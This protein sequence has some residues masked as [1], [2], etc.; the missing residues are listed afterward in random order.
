MLNRDSL[1]I[2][3]IGVL[4]FT[5]GLRPE[6]I[7][8]DCRFAMFAQEMMRNGP[9]F[10][11]TT[12]GQPYPDYPATSTFLIYLVSQLFGKVTPFTAILPTAIISALSLVVIYRIGAMHSRQWA[13]F[14]VLINLF[15]KDF[16][17]LSRSVSQDHYTSLVTVL[18]FYLAY[19][20]TVYGRKKRLCFIP[21]LLI[22][23]FATRGPIGLVIPAAVLCA[24]YFFNMDFKLFALMAFSATILFI[25]CFKGLLVAA[26]YQAGA[27]FA[28]SVWEAQMAGRLGDAK[29]WIGYYWTDSLARYAMAYPF[30]I[31]VVISFFKKIYRREN[32]DYKLLASL[33]VWI[34]VVLIGMS[35]PGTRKI[36]YVL[37]MIPAAALI[38]SYMF[39]E[40]M[41]KGILF[42]IK[43][44]FLQICFGLPFGTL[45][46]ILA[47]WALSGRFEFLSGVN[48]LTLIILLTVLAAAAWRLNNRL[49]ESV[50]RDFVFM[51]IGTL[52]FILIIGGIE[53]PLN[54]SSRRTLP[55]VEKVE[56]LRKQN[57]GDIVFYKIE[58]DGEAIKFMAN[59][60]KPIKPQFINSPE[61]ILNYKEPVYFIAMDEDLD[62]LPKETAQHI[63]RLDTGKIS[64]KDCT[65][66][67]AYGKL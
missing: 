41:Q 7:G 32:K 31:I 29:H 21:L 36:R 30:A 57:P 14:A 51:A 62:N 15:T 13:L 11:P 23:N 18:C 48:Y 5:V 12:Y 3:L 35:I 17:N 39:I 55:F 1:L 38:A 16:L 19:S 6:F 20:A 33:A 50:T 56:S 2:F 34:L 22:A 45:I 44:I 54:Y 66:F 59:L 8:F 4:V 9:T 26:E 25:L 47:A 10:F 42:G 63:K 40:P 64:R 58:A 53:E 43:K 24:Y 65:V 46:F 61:D 52:T 27:V 49:K 67:N 28:D 60:D 37:P